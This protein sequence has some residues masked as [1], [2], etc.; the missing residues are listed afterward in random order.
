[1]ATINFLERMKAKTKATDHKHILQSQVQ[2]KFRLPHGSHIE[3]DYDASVQ[4]WTITLK[5][6]DKEYRVVANGLH[7]GFQQVGKMARKHEI[8]QQVK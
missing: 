1:M 8:A 2:N 3:A 6:G 7:W 5:I 4:K